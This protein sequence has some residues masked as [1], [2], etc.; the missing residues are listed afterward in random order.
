M[1]EI[2]PILLFTIV[3][4]NIGIII[5][6]ISMIIDSYYTVKRFNSKEKQVVKVVEEGITEITKKYKK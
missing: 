4:I 3:M 5:G 2:P 6:S 1:I